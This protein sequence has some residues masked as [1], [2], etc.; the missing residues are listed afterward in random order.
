[1]STGILLVPI[2]LLP[3]YPLKDG[4]I[5]R[6]LFYSFEAPEDDSLILDLCDADDLYSHKMH[7]RRRWTR[8]VLWA[9]GY[10]R[11]LGKG[12]ESIVGL[13]IKGIGG[14]ELQPFQDF[15]ES[16]LLDSASLQ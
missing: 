8:K 7:S 14:T 16:S 1:M 9:D 10:A 15:T 12:I 6:W 5:F 13:L 4:R 11:L 3:V 2:D